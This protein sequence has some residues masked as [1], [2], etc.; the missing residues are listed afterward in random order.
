M[1]GGMTMA[2]SAVFGIYPTR[3]SVEAAVAD[4]QAVG[5][6]STDVS[7]LIPQNVGTTDLAHSKAT[8]A[9][10]GAA[11]GAG[12]AAV[13]GGALGW[14]AGIGALAIPGI[15]PLVAGGPIVA[16]L[17]GVGAFGAV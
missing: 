11:T 14:L 12:S 10:E 3:E 4:L 15:G 16:A 17:A 13:I 6:R 5:F 9:P 7:V 8:K 2:N 1:Q